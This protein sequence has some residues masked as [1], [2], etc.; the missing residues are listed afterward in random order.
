MTDLK[1]SLELRMSIPISVAISLKNNSIDCLSV[2]LSFGSE[3]AC[4]NSPVNNRLYNL[5]RAN[6]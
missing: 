3:N 6:C 1:V 2:P 5:P 4:K